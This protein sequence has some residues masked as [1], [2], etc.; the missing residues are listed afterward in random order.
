MDEKQVRRESLL[1]RAAVTAT[2]A[3]LFL[4]AG[5]F[6]GRSQPRGMFTIEGDISGLTPVSFTSPAASPDTISE[7]GQVNINTATV[8]ELQRLPGVG[9][10]IAQRIVDFRE[11]YGP[12][13]SL[14][15][16]M[17]VSGIGERSIERMKDYITW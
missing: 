9:P 15:D 11:E 1:M 3:A 5:Y 14:E 6:I 12:F 8:T 4:C 10:A 2:V 13:I 17:H 7:D 16:L